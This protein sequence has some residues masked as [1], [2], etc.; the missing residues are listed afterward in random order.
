MGLVQELKK[1]K[2]SI[3]MGYKIPTNLDRY[4]IFS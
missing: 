2:N 3:Q 1:N 4:I